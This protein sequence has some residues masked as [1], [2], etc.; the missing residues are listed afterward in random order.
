MTD[1]P[2]CF[3]EVEP[4]ALGCGGRIAWWCENC[5]ALYPDGDYVTMKHRPL[6]MP[7]P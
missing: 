1:C 7:H 2:Q 4:A 3:S 6:G 5:Q